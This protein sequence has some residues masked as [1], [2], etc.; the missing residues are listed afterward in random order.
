MG[1]L[2][3]T[4]MISKA[5]KECDPETRAYCRR[6]ADRQLGYYK[7]E[8]QE[9]KRQRAEEAARNPPPPPPE[10]K[11]EDEAAEERAHGSRHGHDSYG[12]ERGYDHGYEGGV[13][14]HHHPPPGYY[15][16]D[17]R[18][19]P[20]SSHHPH[21]APPA[22]AYRPPALPTLTPDPAY[23]EGLETPVQDSRKA[24]P[25]EGDG[26]GIS[27]ASPVGSN[28]KDEEEEEA[29]GAPVHGLHPRGAHRPAARYHRSFGR[30]P[31]AAGRAGGAR[32][33][34]PDASNA[35]DEL[36]K[37]RAMYGAKSRLLRTDPRNKRARA[38]GEFLEVRSARTVFTLERI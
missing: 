38:A 9:L 37:R 36:M 5:W 25:G 18:G 35:M 8:L 31:G 33:S 34:P 1:F 6:V 3:L 28:G 19:Q 30:A 11:D 21:G 17:H 14:G 15:R 13:Y 20:P 29:E 7:A 23:A 16:Y 24:H 10:E 22:H 12:G 26:R 2:D 27:R 4:K 32:P